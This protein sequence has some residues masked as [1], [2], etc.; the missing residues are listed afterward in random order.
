MSKTEFSFSARNPQGGLI[1][2]KVKASSEMEVRNRLREGGYKPVSVKQLGK[3]KSGGIDLFAQKV[4]PKDFQ[5]FLR[6]LSVLLKSGVPLLDS[7]QSLEES[8]L[9]PALSR[10]LRF[11]IEDIRE[12]KT[13]SESMAKHPKVFQPMVVNLVK[14]GEQGGILDEVLDRLGTYFEKRKK[15]KSKVVGAL[16]Y[17]VITIV[18]ALS[19]L[20]AILVF[21]I[22]KFEKL[23]E[24]QGQELPHLTQIV[25]KMSHAFTENWY[26]LLF[27]LVVVPGVL[28][29]LYKI[30]P[31]R[32][33]LDA[34]FLKIPLFGDLIKRSSVARMSRTLSTL[35][36]SGIRINDGIDITIGT[37]GNVIVDD[38]MLQAKEGIMAGK[39]FSDPLKKTGF[40]PVIVLQ[41]VS[42]GEKTGNLDSMLEKVADFYEEEVEQTAEQLT[43]LLEPIVIVLLGGM[44]GTLVVAMFLPI[45][46]MGNAF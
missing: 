32:R 16:I 31:L 12:G 36:K 23:F 9:S 42:I 30:G 40:F 39:P 44:I 20:T 8:A 34:I 29:F 45:F 15:L 26:L 14:A 3:D 7:L 19:A 41:M 10:V 1:K 11:I 38:Y 35:L 17:P 13:L 2:G 46:N 4:T 21:V 27:G 24:S 18:V 33:P 43:G 28:S 22:P 25:V 37:M 5:I 6:Q